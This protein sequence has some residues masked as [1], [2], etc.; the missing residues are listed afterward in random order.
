MR[1][2][3]QEIAIILLVII[4][5]AIMIRILRTGRNASSQNEDSSIK[6]KKSPGRTRG[7]LTKSGIVFT[8]TGIILLF[9]GISMFRWAFQSYSWSFIIIIIGLSLVFLSRKFSQFQT[10]VIQIKS[11]REYPNQLLDPS[12]LRN[13]SL[14]FP[15]QPSELVLDE[16]SFP[17]KVRRQRD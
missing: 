6:T 1:P 14:L 15:R 11:Q 5:T 7:F 13:N 2:G 12:G 17:V 4:V 9:A 10:D 3:F 16:L 8:L